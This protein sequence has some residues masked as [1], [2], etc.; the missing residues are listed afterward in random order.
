MYTPF[1]YDVQA[2]A[3]RSG[4]DNFTAFGFYT[5]CFNVRDDLE[6]LSTLPAPSL[7]YSPEIR[8]TLTILWSCTLTIIACVYT[9]L[10]M[11]IPDKCMGQSLLKRKIWWV[12]TALLA[13]ELAVYVSIAQYTQ[14]RQLQKELN[15]C[16]S[17]KRKEIEDAGGDPSNSFGVPKEVS[18]CQLFSP[19]A[20]Y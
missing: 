5:Q 10:H 3:A 16:L 9:A 12:I 17:K 7:V 11:N 4:V 19:Y 6:A 1:E 15:E 2:L 13:P 14:A 18:T 8:G 20:L